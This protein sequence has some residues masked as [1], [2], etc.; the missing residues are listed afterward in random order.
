MKTLT[1]ALTL[2]LS[3]PLAA[4]GGGG[5]DEDPENQIVQETI[6][7]TGALDGL[8]TTNNQGVV[9]AS[10]LA[11]PLVGDG[12]FQ[13]GGPGS[14][15]HVSLW[16]FDLSAIPSDAVITSAT[17]RLRLSGGANDRQMPALIRMDHIRYGAT[18]PQVPGQINTLDFDF[19][20]ITD[21]LTNGFRV[22]DVTAQVQ[23]DVDEDR[24]RSQFRA[25]GA[26]GTNNDDVADI[27]VFTDADN[28]P[29]AARR[30]VLVIEYELP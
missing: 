19:A 14:N 23:D 2:A 25:R 10:P 8:M 4:C 24:G 27:L 16:S 15:V 28:E 29:D 5:G 7:S 6:E 13:Q 26:I 12:P 21:L 1:L 11:A 20:Q 18:F 3:L 9:N 30:P 22:I 17:L